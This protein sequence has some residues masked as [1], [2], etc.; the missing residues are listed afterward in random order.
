MSDLNLQD[1][2]LRPAGVAQKLGVCVASV[3]ARVKS[4]PAFP[5]P[6]K[7]SARTTVFAE[8]EIDAYVRQRAAASRQN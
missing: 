7:L 5:R 6:I 4:D 2:Y 8:S 1:R 3:W